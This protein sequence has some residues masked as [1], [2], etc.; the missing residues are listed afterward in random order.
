MCP[1]DAVPGECDGGSE[2]PSPGGD[3]TANGYG[4]TVCE[5]LGDDCGLLVDSCTN[6]WLCARGPDGGPVT[7]DFDAAEPPA[8]Q[9]SPPPQYCGGAGPNRCGGS[10]NL[11]PSDAACV[12]RECSP[13]DCG[14]LGD[15]CASRGGRSRLPSRRF[16][17]LPCGGGSADSV[18]E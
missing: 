10:T 7:L 16:S 12:P 3:A 1:V 15:G 18:H 9:A 5:E 17:L 8:S 2:A 11:A 14:Q 6:I 13:F 4:P